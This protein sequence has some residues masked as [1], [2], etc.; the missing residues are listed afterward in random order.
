MTAPTDTLLPTASTGAELEALIKRAQSGD[1]SA[2]PALRPYLD[3]H[4]ELWEEYGDLTR[5]AEKTL[6]VAAAQQNLYSRE[7]ITRKLAELKQELN[8][9]SAEARLLVDRIAANWL[10]IC[11]AESDVT[12]ARQMVPEATAYLDY[13]ERRL[14]FAQNRYLGAIRTFAAVRKLLG[15]AGPPARAASRSAKETKPDFA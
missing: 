1:R 9:T 4:R 13:L 3:R 14:T 7:C 12:Y 11:I 8:A 10:A 15:R 6:I 2:V 5:L